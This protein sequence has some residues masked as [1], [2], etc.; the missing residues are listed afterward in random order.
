MENVGNMEP[1]LLLFQYK[2]YFDLV[3]LTEK[4]KL[5]RITTTMD[6][7]PHLQGREI[8]S[9][10]THADDVFVFLSSPDSENNHKTELLKI[11]KLHGAFEIIPFP[12]EPLQMKEAFS[13]AKLFTVSTFQHENTFYKIWIHAS[14]SSLHILSYNIENKQ[15]LVFNSLKNPLIANSFMDHH[16]Y[17][18]AINLGQGIGSSPNIPII[19]GSSVA[20]L[21][22]K[23]KEQKIYM[24][25]DDLYISVEDQKAGFTDLVIINTK[26][27][28]IQGNSYEA[29]LGESFEDEVKKGVNSIV[30]EGYLYQLSYNS[31]GLHLRQLEIGTNRV[32]QKK[33]WADEAEFNRDFQTRSMRKFDGQRLK[34]VEKVNIWENFDRS[35][36]LNIQREGDIE[37]ITIGSHRHMKE[38]SSEESTLLYNTIYENLP[39]VGTLAFYK[40]ESSINFSNA[41]Y[42]F[43]HINLM[44]EAAYYYSGVK[45]YQGVSLFNSKTFEIKSANIIADK[46]TGI[47]EHIHEK[48]NNK[49]T[50][51]SLFRWK[52]KI[53]FGYRRE[54]KYYLIEF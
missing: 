54:G 4:I 41:S 47:M 30:Y 37:R 44:V 1:L 7:P 33:T 39:R 27:W 11:S 13:I 23:V 12:E 35:L 46:W 51:I 31:M 20:S 3:F 34:R 40:S 17:R 24:I 8:Q 15:K 53:Y 9:I 32:I 36:T 6:L 18:F 21:I 14:S 29:E 52:S 22:S 48:I 42:P 19:L 10:I 50:E 5:G 25:G 45:A 49:N 16:L 28:D 38:L 43:S 2:S 26:T